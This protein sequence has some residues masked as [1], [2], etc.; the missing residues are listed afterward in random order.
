MQAVDALHFLIHPC[1]TA[2]EDEEQ[3]TLRRIY[4][5][6]ARRMTAK[7]VMVVFLDAREKRL[8]ERRSRKSKR[9]GIL[10]DRL[11]DALGNRIVVLCRN[12]EIFQPARAVRRTT[13][14]IRD[15]LAECG[16]CIDRRT[17]TVAYGEYTEACVSVG[18]IALNKQGNFAKP[19]LI[20]TALSDLHALSETQRAEHVRRRIV[21]DC[22]LSGRRAITT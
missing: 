20:H 19:T 3:K 11:T 22:E 21:Y 5:D 15:K 9:L 12:W 14:H 10:V 2:N 13:E 8:R 1:Y 18:A 6:A 4:V 17:P 16:F 7:E